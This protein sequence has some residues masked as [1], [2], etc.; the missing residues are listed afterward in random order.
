MSTALG[1]WFLILILILLNGFLAMSEIAIVAA[2]KARLEDRAKN[3]DRKS[4]VALDLARSPSRFL[5]AVQVGITLIGVALGAVGSGSTVVALSGLLKQLGLS[6]LLS[7]SI[8]LT[9][10]LVTITLLTVVLGELVPKRLALANPEGV[11]AI[12]AI[13]MRTFAAVTKPAVSLLSA[14]TKLI[15]RLLGVEPSSEPPV[16]DEEVRIILTEGTEAGVFEEV[17]QDMVQRVLMLDDRRVSAAMTPRP[18]IA[19]LN[20]E[21]PP[22]VLQQQIMESTY[23]RLPVARGSLDDILGEIR[24]RDVLI[25]L[26]CGEQVDL[27]DH[28][29]DPLYVPEIMPVLKVLE[30]LKIAGTEMALVLNEYGS[31]EGLITLRDIL[32]AIVGDIPSADEDREPEAVLRE[33]GSWLIDGLLPTDELKELIDVEDLPGEANGL[34][35]TMAGFMIA[36]LGRFPHASDHFSCRGWRFEVVDMDGHRVDKVLVSREAEPTE[37]SEESLDDEESEA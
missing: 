31:I 16:S 37:V 1:E 33:D 14:T 20:V 19:W 36:R 24:A 2:R 17:E 25:A 22:E 32:E 13:P 12:V 9:F 3:G 5:S 11:A 28:L 18:D 4:G 6:A 21:D 15:V 7:Q 8:A 27:T 34:F 35:Q 26:R 10:I 23:S 29:R 30:S